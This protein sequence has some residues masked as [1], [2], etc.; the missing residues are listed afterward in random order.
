[1]SN[2]RP[3]PSSQ[4]LAPSEL[5]KNFSKSDMIAAFLQNLALPSI[6]NRELTT[7]DFEQWDRLLSPYSVPAIEYAFDN[8]GRNGGKFPLP[9]DIIGLIDAYS[10]TNASTFERVLPAGRMPLDNY[11]PAWLW[12]YVQVI[13]RAEQAK[14]EQIPYVPFND[15]EIK[16]LHRKSEEYLTGAGRRA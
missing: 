13:D 1:M 6:F 3:L 12:M 16:E 9:K 8:W 7:A 2:Q 11:W 14:K 4:F 15:Q 5:P 10:N